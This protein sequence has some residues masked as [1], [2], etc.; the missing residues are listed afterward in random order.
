[1]EAGLNYLNNAKSD[2]ERATN[3]KGGHRQNALR[4]VDEAIDEVKLGIDAGRF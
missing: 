4:L 1:M 2:L 3:D